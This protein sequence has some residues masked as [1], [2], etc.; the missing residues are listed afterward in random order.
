ML[1]TVKLQLKGARVRGTRGNGVVI[2][3]IQT[4]N[5][6]HCV[7]PALAGWE[8]LGSG[9]LLLDQI[10]GFDRLRVRCAFL[11]SFDYFLLLL[12]CNCARRHLD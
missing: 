5:S 12:A 8:G 9:P 4:V 2:N 1:K 3:A 11:S 7:V 6:I 10:I